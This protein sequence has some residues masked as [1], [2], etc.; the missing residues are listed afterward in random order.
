MIHILRS[1]K[2]KQFRVVYAAAN[3]EPLAVSE[4]L[5]SKQS[6]KKNIR[7]VMK[8]ADTNWQGLFQ[9]DTLKEPAVFRLYLDNSVCPTT[10][11]ITRCNVTL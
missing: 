9:D 5:K 2:T 1:K 11:A 8:L 7:G 6:A 3:G 4:P 10:F